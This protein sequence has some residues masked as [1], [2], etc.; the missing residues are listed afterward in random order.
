MATTTK[1]TPQE[2]HSGQEHA[3]KNARSEIKA[4]ALRVG[5][6]VRVARR[7]LSNWRKTRQLKKYSFMKQWLYE[8]FKVAEVTRPSK[9]KAS[10]YKLLGPDGKLL[11]RWFIRQD[12]LKIDRGRG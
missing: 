9:T 1:Q 6:S 12:L 2:V 7:A 5:N 3:V 4:R 11:D 10:M 8:V